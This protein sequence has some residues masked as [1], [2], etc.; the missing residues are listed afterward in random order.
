MPSIDDPRGYGKAHREIR[1]RWRPVVEAGEAT[2]VRCLVGI[3][4]P[5]EGCPKCG[6]EV[7]KGPPTPGYCGWDVGHDDVD[8]SLYT[9]TE[10][11]CC[12]R[13]AGGRKAARKAAVNRHIWSREWLAQ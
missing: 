13:R 11:S 4:P 3:N 8:R 1:A 10:H 6:R 7:A 5:G 12:N 2:C 9:G